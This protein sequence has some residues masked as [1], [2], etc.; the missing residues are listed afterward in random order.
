MHVRPEEI[1]NA[2]LVL[3]RALLWNLK[4]PAVSPAQV[5]H[6]HLRNTHNCV[7]VFSVLAAREDS[8]EATTSHTAEMSPQ[9]WSSKPEP[10][11]QRHQ[12]RQPVPYQWQQ[13]LLKCRCPYSGSVVRS[14][15]HVSTWPPTTAV[16]HLAGVPFNLPDLTNPHTMTSEMGTLKYFCRLGC[17]DPVAQNG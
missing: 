10:L 4:T 13:L 8:R 9:C 14:W 11:L 12:L 2:G 17:T 6:V 5:P 16:P 1:E 3:H 7:S 15:G